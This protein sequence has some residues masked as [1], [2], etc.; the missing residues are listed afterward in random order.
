MSWQYTDTVQDS[1]RQRDS[2]IHSRH[3]LII[4]EPCSVK[5]QTEQVWKQSQSALHLRTPRCLPDVGFPGRCHH[6]KG[7]PA[8]V[9]SSLKRHVIYLFTVVKKSAVCSRLE[10]RTI[11][12]L[13]LKDSTKVS[14]KVSKWFPHLLFFLWQLLI[15]SSGMFEGKSFLSGFHIFW[16]PLCITKLSAYGSCK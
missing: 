5:E 10:T 14:F 8:R 2:V 6:N 3:T 13:F 15:L 11:W 12:H 4:L 9:L 1:E 7:I 16:I